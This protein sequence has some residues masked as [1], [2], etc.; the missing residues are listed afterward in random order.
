MDIVGQAGSKP[1]V[2]QSHLKKLFAGV[3]TAVFS[4]DQ[5]NITGVESLEGERVELKTPVS[6]TGPDVEIWLSRLVLEI[7]S[8]LQIMMRECIDE[9]RQTEALN[10]ARFP[11]Q[12]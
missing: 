6:V 11:S 9:L 5:C 8:T 7:Q 2:I 3:H 4:A 12:M 10:L 1:S